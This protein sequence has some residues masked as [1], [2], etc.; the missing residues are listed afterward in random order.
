M[1]TQKQQCI[2]VI[3]TISPEFIRESISSHSSM[4]GIGAH[5]IFPGQFRN[6]EIDG[7]AV[8]PI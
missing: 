8:M 7:R 3:G 4:T 1:N 2:F 5:G 6:D